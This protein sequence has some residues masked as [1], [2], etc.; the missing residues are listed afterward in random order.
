MLFAAMRPSLPRRYD[1][2]DAVPDPESERTDDD[3]RDKITVEDL[4]KQAGEEAFEPVELVAPK[5]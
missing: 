5:L 4:V 1:M 2:P 3:A